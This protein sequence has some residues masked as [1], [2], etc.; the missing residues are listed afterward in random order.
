MIPFKPPLYGETAFNCPRCHAYANQQWFQIHIVEGAYAPVAGYMV[1]RCYH[2]RQVS[3]WETKGMFFPRMSSAPA[4]AID[5]PA[6]V[7]G[8]YEEAQE[9]LGSSP[10]AAAALLRLCVQELCL[11]FGLPGKDLNA[12]IAELVRR[13]LLP[14]V[15]KALDIVRVI[16]NNAVHP[17]QIDI[18]D[19]TA[20]ATKLFT[21]VNLVVEI[22]ITQPKHIDALYEALP[23]TSQEQI[24]RRDAPPPKKGASGR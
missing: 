1:A 3:F 22:M 14:K 23:Q 2:C 12:D 10:R 6:N 17:G 13:G 24:A 18:Q 16:G 21:L 15:Q 5:M 11:H 20:T 9:V 4:P 19:D 8:G 7:R